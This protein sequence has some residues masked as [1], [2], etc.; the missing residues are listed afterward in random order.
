MKDRKKKNYNLIVGG[1]ITGMIL[2]FVLT[3]QE[4]KHQSIFAEQSRNWRKGNELFLE[5]KKEVMGMKKLV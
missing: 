5:P 2:L 1:T 3:E 4:L